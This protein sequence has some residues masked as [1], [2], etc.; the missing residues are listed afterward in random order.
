MV[1]KIPH[2][3][4]LIIVDNTGKVV[5]N[6]SSTKYAPN[7]Y[8]YIGIILVELKSKKQ[9]VAFKAA[10]GNMVLLHI[11]FLHFSVKSLYSRDLE[12]GS[13]P[14]PPK[15]AKR[16]ISDQAGSYDRICP[17]KQH[18]PGFDGHQIDFDHLKVRMKAFENQDLWDNQ[19]LQP[20][21]KKSEPG[22]FKKFLSGITKE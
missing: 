2:D 13:L 19:T 17:R 7:S 14:I 5:A 11:S 3:I 6:F 21:K 22:I 12:I 16:R 10:G 20:N 15:P 4:I 1:L 9:T 8:A 18:G